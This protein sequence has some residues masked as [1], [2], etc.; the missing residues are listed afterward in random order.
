MKDP[1]P[2]LATPL[3]LT[4]Q[5]L[6][7]ILAFDNTF[8]AD[9]SDLLLKWFYWRTVIDPQEMMGALLKFTLKIVMAVGSE[10]S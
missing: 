7:R 9:N 1:F 2:I 8:L 5:L 6:E 3:C 4:E 10:I